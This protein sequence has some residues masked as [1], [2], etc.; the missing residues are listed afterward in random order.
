MIDIPGVLEDL[1][2][3]ELLSDQSTMQ[4][5][6]LKD[7]EERCWHYDHQLQLWLTSSGAATIAFVEDVV[8]NQQKYRIDNDKNYAMPSSTDL[9]MAHLG[10]NYWTTYNLLSQI[11]GPLKQAAPPT[12]EGATLPAR[13]DPHHYCR[14]VSLLIPYFQT[15]GVGSYYVSFVGFATTVAMSFIVRQCPSEDVSALRILLSKAFHGEHGAHLRRF[16]ATWPWANPQESEAMGRQMSQS[17][18]LGRWR[19]NG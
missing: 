5:F 4:C 12:V 8:A 3:I 1:S 19:G 18:G 2:R 6:L 13:F 14:L 10:L 9:A 7:L 11:I 16:L 17:Q 15:P